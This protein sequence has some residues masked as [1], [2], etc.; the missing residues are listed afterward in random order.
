ME[1]L[2]NLS[3]ILAGIFRAAAEAERDVVDDADPAPAEQEPP[4]VAL[5]PITIGSDGLATGDQVERILTSR[6]GYQWRTKTGK[7]GGMLWHWT[8]TSH[9]T[10]R[11]MVKRTS[12]GSGNSV[13]FWIDANGTIFQQVATTKGAG[14]AG[15]KSSAKLRELGGVIVADK[16]GRYSANS[17][18]IGIELV[19]VG[20]VRE[21]GGKWLGWP[22]GKDGERSP[23]VP[24]DQVRAARDRGGRLRH[25]QAFTP[26]Q[27]DAAERLTRAVVARYG[28]TRAACAW[29]HVDVDPGRKSDPGPLWQAGDLP[30]ILD[31]VFGTAG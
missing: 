25:Y 23:V 7:P 30:Q 27:V 8:S 15:G 5:A 4:D 10:G 28:L 20:E 12:G 17:F 21:V 16:A 22:Y 1:A 29:G 19:C 24:A 14:H 9:G 2:R 6:G 18:L 13:H 31:R 11:S 26:A 3:G